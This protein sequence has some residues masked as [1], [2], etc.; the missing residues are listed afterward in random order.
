MD[1]ITGWGLA[2]TPHGSAYVAWQGDALCLLEFADCSPCPAFDSL[3]R[4]DALAKQWVL[5]A[6]SQAVTQTK[7]VF[8][9]GTPFQ[10]KVWQ[11]LM[12]IAA[13][14]T[15]SYQELAHAIGHSTAARAV[16]SAVGSNR[17]AV[18]VPCHRVLRGD[19][20][21]AG[22]RWGVARKQQL[23]ARERDAD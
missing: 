11:A 1:T 8:L 7:M 22:Y 17:I 5:Q 23:L 6:F 14:S 2:E 15:M 10:R 9:Q 16:G 13:G 19:G 12:T 4:N 20:A 3:L 21:L 18:L